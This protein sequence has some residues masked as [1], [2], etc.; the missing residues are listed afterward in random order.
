MLHA[1]ADALLGAGGLGDLGRLFPADVRTP[2]G[3]ASTELLTEVVRR[4]A[5]VGLRREHGH[6]LIGAGPQLGAR[7]D[8]MRGAIAGLLGRG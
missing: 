1:V 5:V 4:L 7:L 2:R 6:R 8:L 3:I